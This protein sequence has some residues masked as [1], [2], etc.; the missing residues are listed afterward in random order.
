MIA[1]GKRIMESTAGNTTPVKNLFT[2][3]VAHV[4]YLH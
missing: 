1:F 2:K 3:T 4:R